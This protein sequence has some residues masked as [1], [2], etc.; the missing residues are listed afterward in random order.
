MQN[1]KKNFFKIINSVSQVRLFGVKIC[2]PKFNSIQ[3]L[4][5]T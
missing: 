5:Y 1:S 4:E 3:T 2:Q